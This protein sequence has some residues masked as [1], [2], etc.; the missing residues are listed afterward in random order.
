MFIKR[1]D[2]W[3]VTMNEEDLPSLRL[4][5]RYRQMLTAKAPIKKLRST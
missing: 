2:A 4:S 5:R 1:G 3:V